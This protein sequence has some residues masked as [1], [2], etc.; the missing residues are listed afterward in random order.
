MDAAWRNNSMRKDNLKAAVIGKDGRTSAIERCLLKSPRIA[1]PLLQFP[2]WQGRQATENILRRAR[3]KNPH[4]FIVGSEQPLA[5][6]TVDSL[7]K[8]GIPSVGPLQTLAKFESSKAFTR[9]L[10]SH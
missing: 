5:E 8:T 2:E 6:S 3:E 7:Q 4:F 1:E 10:L 9:H